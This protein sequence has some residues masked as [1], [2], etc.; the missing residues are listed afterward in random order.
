[1]L[2]RG[3]VCTFR[4]AGGKIA[5]ASGKLRVGDKLLAVNGIYVRGHANATRSLK[6]AVGELRLKLERE[7]KELDVILIKPRLTSKLGIILSSAAKDTGVPVVTG[8]GGASSSSSNS[9]NSTLL[10]LRMLS[11][12]ARS[13][14]SNHTSLHACH[15]GMSQQTRTDPFS[16]EE[17]LAFF[18]APCCSTFPYRQVPFVYSTCTI[19]QRPHPPLQPARRRG[20]VQ[21]MMKPTGIVSMCRL[22]V[23]GKGNVYKH[24]VGLVRTE[25]P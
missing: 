1:M 15:C 7:E 13:H 23:L 18:D 8:L 20:A 9:S 6:T 21:T 10:P 4:A 24:G 2:P 5:A 12:W 17:A 3:R 25:K 16:P 19:L 22:T 14:S 11:H